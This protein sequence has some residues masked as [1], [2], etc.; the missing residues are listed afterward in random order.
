MCFPLGF[1]CK[2]AVFK[3]L[4]MSWFNSPID[5]KEIELLFVD[6]KDMKNYQLELSGFA[7]EMCTSNNIINIETDFDITREYINFIVIMHN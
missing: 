3:A 1:S 6:K 4:G 7:K 5:W 2:E